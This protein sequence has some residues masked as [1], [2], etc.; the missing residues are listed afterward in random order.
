MTEHMKATLVGQPFRN[1]KGL[2]YQVKSE[3]RS[4]SLG[5]WGA[6]CTRYSL[7]RYSMTPFGLTLIAWLTRLPTCQASECGFKVAQ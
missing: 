1:Q 3:E 2:E 4:R 5:A 7:R 6:E